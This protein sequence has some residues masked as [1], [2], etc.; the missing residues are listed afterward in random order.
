LPFSPTTMEAIR[1]DAATLGLR[2]PSTISVALREQLVDEK[3]GKMD[4]R[5]RE[6]HVAGRVIQRGIA[7][8]LPGAMR[9]TGLDQLSYLAQRAAEF[10]GLEPPAVD[11]V[12]H[13][14]GGARVSLSRSAAAH[15]VVILPASRKP[16]ETPD[17][18]VDLYVHKTEADAVGKA[19][20]LQAGKVF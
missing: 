1:R 19:G 5:A 6:Y 14:L 3:I 11:C 7:A 8:P 10:A 16:P 2:S 17:V 9:I 12:K 13:M 4:G 15:V 18:W 20:T